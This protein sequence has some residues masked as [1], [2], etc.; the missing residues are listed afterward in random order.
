M[1]HYK[2]NI[3]D[4]KV[5]MPGNSDRFNTLTDLVDFHQQKPLSRDG[6]Y[7]NKPCPR[8]SRRWDLVAWVTI[9]Y[10]TV[11]SHYSRWAWAL[12]IPWDVWITCLSQLCCHRCCCCCHH[13][14]CIRICY[15]Y[16]R[17]SVSVLF[18]SGVL[19]LCAACPYVPSPAHL[20]CMF[21]GVH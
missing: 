3:E 18:V 20:R 11:Y 9:F 17:V 16:F 10:C 7:L 15:F 4:G 6:K 14:F 12:S 1:N 5:R 19:S 21:S 8:P 13:C 2:I